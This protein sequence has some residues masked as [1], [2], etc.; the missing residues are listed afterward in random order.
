MKD[1]KLLLSKPDTTTKRGIRDI[2]LISLLYDSGCHVSEF[3]KI[4]VNDI[5]FKRN[6]ISILD[7]GRKQGQVLISSNVISILSKYI[8]IYNLQNTD[9]RFINSRSEKLTRPGIIHIINKY[10]EEYRK[11]NKDFFKKQ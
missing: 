10:K 4:K 5:D 6:T 7:K 3:T 1:I 8:T 9:Y 11:E 2:A